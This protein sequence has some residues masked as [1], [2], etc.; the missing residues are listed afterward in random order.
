MGHSI[1]KLLSKVSFDEKNGYVLNQSNR[2][3]MTHFLHH[4]SYC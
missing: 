4:R 3:Y 1:V 2:K